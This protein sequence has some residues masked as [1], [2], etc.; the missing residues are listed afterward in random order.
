[1]DQS[2][3][4]IF[5]THNIFRR[6]NITQPFRKNMINSIINGCIMCVCMSMIVFIGF[7]IGEFNQATVSS[8]DMENSVKVHQK[9]KITVNGSF[10]S[11]GSPCYKRYIIDP[12]CKHIK[13][14]IWQSHYAHLQMVYDFSFNF[15]I[16]FPISGN[17]EIMCNNINIFCNVTN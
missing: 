14:Y 10:N 8:I 7:F 2:Y 9:T 16:Y 11:V 17:W 3:F 4:R 13:I 1:M 5:Q 6:S 12:I 15:T